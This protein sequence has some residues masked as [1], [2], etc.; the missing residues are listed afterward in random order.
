MRRARLALVLVLVLA[1]A[2]P[3][4]A[5]ASTIIGKARAETLRGSA[6]G[7]LIHAVGGGRDSVRCGRGIDTVMA[8]AAD[9]VALDCEVVARRIAVDTSRG[10][11]AHATVVERGAAGGGAGGAGVYQSG[12]RREGTVALGFA[13]SH[14][15]GPP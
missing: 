15:A 2:L 1:G 7:D 12:R 4:S 6:R 5:A 10:P 13:T 11:G 3:G 8:D 9:R 14:D